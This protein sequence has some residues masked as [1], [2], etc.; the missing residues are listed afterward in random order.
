MNQ[1][2]SQENN[3]ANRFRLV[4]LGGLTLVFGLHYGQPAAAHD[5]SSLARALKIRGTAGHERIVTH[6]GNDVIHAGS[7]DDTITCNTA[8]NVINCGAGI[9]LVYTIG[10]G[11]TV[12]GDADNDAF[13]V[14][15]NSFTLI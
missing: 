5:P 6:N 2:H 13:Q 14:T 10:A 4:I 7:G 3:Q 9:D 12:S 8:A 15:N 11:D 1:F